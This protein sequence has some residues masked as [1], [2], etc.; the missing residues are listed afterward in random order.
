MQKEFEMSML[1]EMK[2]FL[3]LQINQSDK[4]IFISQTK[5]INEMLKKF[6]MDDSKPVGTPMVTGCKLRKFD[7]SKNVEQTMYR[8][9]IGSLLYATVTRSNIMHS[10]CQ[11]G[12]FQAS[13]K[14]SH[15]LAVKIIFRYLKGTAEYGLWYPSGRQLDL[16]AFTDVDWAG[17]IDDRKSTSGAAF[18]LGGCLV[19]WS[20]KKQSAI[21][22]STVETEYI[23]AANCGAWVVWMKQMLEEIRIHYDESIP[24]FCDNTSAISISKNL[25]MHSKT[26]HIPIKYHFLRDQ[27]MSKIVKL[28]YVGTK[29]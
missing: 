11:A 26:K 28:E 1:G 18:F 23:A 27:V 20:S 12:R 22:L 8:S 3:G 5:Y 9:M 10:V 2:F 7:E 17:C 4:G 24:I 6:Q 21:S 16:C 25:V 19:S 29:D 13:P 14:A 15:L